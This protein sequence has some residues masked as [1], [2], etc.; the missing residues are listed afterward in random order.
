MCPWRR[1]VQGLP[2]SPSW[3]GALYFLFL[4]FKNRFIGTVFSS[5][6]ILLPYL[7]N[8][9]CPGFLWLW[10][11]LLYCLKCASL[12]PCLLPRV[13]SSASRV[14]YPLR[15]CRCLHKGQDTLMTN[16]PSYPVICRSSYFFSCC[17]SLSTWLPHWLP[18]LITSQIRPLMFLFSSPWTLGSFL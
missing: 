16:S 1:W 10:C 12:S 3:S 9:L 15:L 17:W 14:L 4:F 2:L 18:K 11:F 8:M 13:L 7:H 5:G 6:G